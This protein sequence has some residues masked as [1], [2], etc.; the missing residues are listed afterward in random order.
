MSMRSDSVKFLIVVMILAGAFVVGF[1]RPAAAQEGAPAPGTEPIRPPTAVLHPTFAL[2]DADGRSVLE[3]GAPVS[4]MNSC[5]TC[6]DTAF[7]ARHSFHTDVGLSDYT[8][9]GETENGRVWDSSTGI[10]GKW[11]PITYRYLSPEGDA[12]LDL[13]TPGWIQAFGARHVGGGPAETS[14]SGARLTDLP[15]SAGV[16]DTHVV[17]PQSGELVAWDWEAS[18][19]VEMNCFLCHTPQPNNAARIAALQAGAFQ[20]ANT[21]TLAGTG[22]VAQV[23][24]GWQW[25]PDAFNAEGE[26][27]DAYVLVQE[28]SSLNCAQCHGLVHVDAQTPLAMNGCSPDQWSTITTGQII[29]PQRLSNSGM[30]LSSKA[31]LARSWDIH[32]ERI[33]GCTDCHYSINNPIYYREAEATRPAHLTFDPRR[34]DLGEYL[35][36][37]MHQFAKGQSAQGT[38]APEFDNS[39]RRCESCHSIAVTH[40]WLPYKEKHT[41]VLSCE[42]CHVPRMHAPA[43][44]ALDWTVLRADGTPQATCRGV[45]MEP[46][47]PGSSNVLVYGFDPVLLPRANGDGTTSLAPFNL[48]SAWFWVYGAPERPAP[49]RDLQAAWLD[50]D[51][52]YHADVLAAFDANG[53]G[54]LDDDELIIDNAAKESLIAGR[55]AALGLENPRIAAEVRPYNINHTVAH[56]EWATKECRECH[57]ATSRITQPMLLADQMPGGVMPTFVSSAATQ[58]AG[59]LQVTDTGALLYQPQ[60]QPD[61]DSPLTAL[62]ILGH[63]SVRWVDLAGAIIFLGTVAGVTLHGGLRFFLA[64]RRTPAEPA[65]REVYMY[66]VY[67]RL[68]HWLQTA[69]IFGLIFTG[70]VIHKPDIFGIFSFRFMVEVHNVLA[71][72]L[73]AN[74]TLAAFYHLASGEIRQ[75]LPQPRGFFNQ[76]F[77][78]VTFYVRGIF[79]GEPHPFEKSPERKLNP[80]QQITYFGLLNVLLPLQVI[81]GILMWGAQRWPNVAQQLGGLPFLAPFH[82]LIAW[83]FGAFI[84]M[85]VY[86]TTTGHAPLAGVRSMIMGWDAVEV[87]HADSA[88]AAAD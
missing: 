41:A 39:I 67:E 76:A 43:R 55:L 16:V 6:H 60:T 23:D 65:L 82:T 7:I 21:A 12:R 46:G 66:T 85:H 86:L 83:L 30:N 5:G 35:Y 59:V 4:T 34:I 71:F 45:E 2:L 53:D 9:P 87:H 78:Q 10:F 17:D 51:G 73:L 36:R 28:P 49:F 37:P 54:T 62:Y 13:T 56:G 32:A 47:L 57:S 74:A 25:Q 68:W 79:R 84:V 88:E 26:L 58:M 31:S 18:G 1:W 75:F 77:A 40:D 14:R 80:L 44:Q 22:I 64:R 24:G 69:V 27:L 8:A 38:L 15:A 61:T 72:I 48:I 63:D 33:V 11:N 42:T 3:S 70:L 81:T 52:R 29:S 20:W 19:V 50:A